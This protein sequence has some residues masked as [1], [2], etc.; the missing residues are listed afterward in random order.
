MESSHPVENLLGFTRFE[1]K[2]V[3]FRSGSAVVKVD[4]IEL[5]A[6]DKIENARLA[7]K[8]SAIVLRRNGHCENTLV[9]ILE[10]DIDP[11]WFF[12]GWFFLVLVFLLV[13]V[14]LLVLISLF[15]LFAFFFV[16]F[17]CQG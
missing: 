10:I 4:R 11:N 6:L 16:A 17:R 13:S 14:G 1:L 12:F 9:D 15:G 5:R 8:K 2:L 7:R 3:D